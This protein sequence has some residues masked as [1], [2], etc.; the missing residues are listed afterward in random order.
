MKGG[1][2]AH[3]E[4]TRTYPIELKKAWDYLNDP[5]RWPEWYTGLV[6][7]ADPDARWTETGDEIG[8][9]Y[10]LLGRTI[11]GECVVD[12]VDPPVMIA[13]TGRVPGLPDIRT[14]WRHTDLGSAFTTRV[15]LETGEPTSFFGRVVDRMLIPRAL[16]R[17]LHRTLDALEDLFS[18]GAAD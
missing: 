17:D 14:E 13:Y 7:V 11:E 6:E 18:M 4:L 1:T 9:S 3:V 15:T 2:M 8:F 12:Q 16:G 10:R 5:H